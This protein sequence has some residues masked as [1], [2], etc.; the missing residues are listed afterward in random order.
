MVHLW[1][2]EPLRPR[3]M[4][5]SCLVQDNVSVPGQVQSA[6]TNLADEEFLG[7]VP[8]KASPWNSGDT[9]FA[10]DNAEDAVLM[11][12]IKSFEKSIHQN[13]EAGKLQGEGMTRRAKLPRPD[14]LGIFDVF[15]FRFSSFAPTVSPVI[16]F[17]KISL[18]FDQRQS[19]E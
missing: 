8:S 14:W 18:R 19:S 6:L 10:S 17:L 9:H 11:T 13:M 2:V 5:C 1:Q 3:I 15:R 4:T 16:R 7:V 12:R